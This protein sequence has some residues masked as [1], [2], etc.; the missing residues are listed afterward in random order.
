LTAAKNDNGEVAFSNINHKALLLTR[1]QFIAVVTLK[2]I[3][4]EYVKVG[5]ALNTL[6]APHNVAV[7]NQ[8]CFLR[9]ADSG[10]YV[11]NSTR[12]L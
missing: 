1:H 10:G 4:S 6:A 12:S 3:S 7:D 11:E 8:A 9:Y 5:S 2:I